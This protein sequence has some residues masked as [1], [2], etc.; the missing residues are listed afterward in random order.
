MKIIM[1]YLVNAVDLLSW[2]DHKP[3]PGTGLH[4]ERLTFPLKTFRQKYQNKRNNVT[5]SPNSR[6]SSVRELAVTPRQQ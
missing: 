3:T 2:V 6:L 5:G 4:G 1:C